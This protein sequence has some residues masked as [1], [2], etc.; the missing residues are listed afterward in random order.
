MLYREI[1]IRIKANGYDACGHIPKLT[2][3]V[4]TNCDSLPNSD[5][6]PAVIIFPGGGYSFV[7]EREAEPIA[8]KYLSMGFSAFILNYSVSPSVYPTALLEAMYSIRYIRENAEELGINPDKIAV[9]GFSA[10]GHLAAS[11]SCFWNEPFISEAL[12]IKSDMLKPN[13]AVL[14]YP[15]ISSGSCAHI[16]SFKSLL[17]KR[18]GA[19][20]LMQKLSLEN[21]VNANT[22]PSFLWHTF[23]DGLVPVQNSLLYASALQN[24]DIPFELH[25]YQHGGHGLS[26][27]NEIT[28]DV[29]P[30]CQNWID[31]SG[32]WIKNL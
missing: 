14:S 16:D 4:P 30:D 1:D 5:N 9:V 13:A 24:A 10:G 32:R 28:G 27:A 19:P 31:M 29:M 25:I 18:F 12:G 23:E 2:A 20:E 8:M 17:G 15:V 7:S 3:F 21:S 26:L 22:P 11:V 6:R